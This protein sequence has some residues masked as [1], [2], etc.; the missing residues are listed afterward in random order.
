MQNLKLRTRGAERPI[1]YAPVLDGQIRDEVEAASRRFLLEDR[2]NLEIASQEIYNVHHKSLRPNSREVSDI[3]YE[4]T[5]TPPQEPSEKPVKRSLF[6]YSDWRK[7]V[8]VGIALSTLVLVINVSLVI[9]AGQGARSLNGQIATMYEGNC[10][11]MRK[12]SLWLHLLIHVLSSLPLGAGNYCMQVLCAPTERTSI[13]RT[14]AKNGCRLA[15][16]R[17]VILARL[18]EGILSSGRF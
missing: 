16:N 4:H 6:R 5:E 1:V 8:A 3:H 18:G 9:A 15:C 12:L 14:G 7:G 17:S 11:E 10:G 13:L 2:Q